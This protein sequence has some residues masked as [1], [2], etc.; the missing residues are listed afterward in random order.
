MI[1]ISLY[2]NM[3][4]SEKFDDRFMLDINKEELYNSIIQPA[5]KICIDVRNVKN[6]EISITEENCLKN[7]LEKISKNILS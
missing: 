5:I 4:D 6:S 3:N 7:Y 1:I 2:L